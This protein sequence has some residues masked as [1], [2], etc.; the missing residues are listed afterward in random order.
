[1]QVPK[2]YLRQKECLL[3]LSRYIDKPAINHIPNPSQRITKD[4]LVV[5][6]A[7]ES[8]APAAAGHRILRQ[9]EFAGSIPDPSQN[10]YVSVIIYVYVRCAYVKQ[11]K[12]S[13]ATGEK[14]RK[15]ETYLRT[16]R[17][18]HLGLTSISWFLYPYYICNVCVCIYIYILYIYIYTE[19][20]HTRSGSPFPPCPCNDPSSHLQQRAATALKPIG[21]NTSCNGSNTWRQLWMVYPCLSKN[22]RKLL[23]CFFTIRH[24]RK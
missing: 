17:N 9:A 11:N 2:A 4:F 23:A 1:M 13:L 20:Y 16:F 8:P 5:Q 18:I 10:V 21:A 14:K 22:R 7:K 24:W 12:R 15:V 19:S 3:L 6:A